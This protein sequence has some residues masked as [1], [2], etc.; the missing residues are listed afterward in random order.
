MIWI[1]L[2]S[3][4]SSITAALFCS[5]YFAFKYWSENK[6]GYKMAGGYRA[7]SS[8]KMLEPDLDK[9]KSELAINSAILS[10][11]LMML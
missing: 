3:R 2:S 11:Y 4:F 9:I 1:A 5:R 10:S 8:Q 7:V 6:P